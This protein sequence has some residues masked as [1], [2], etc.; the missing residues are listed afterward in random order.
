MM[1]YSIEVHS[2]NTPTVIGDITRALAVC[3]FFV[4]QG[5]ATRLSTA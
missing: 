3:S 5:L 4:S 2:L 1:Y